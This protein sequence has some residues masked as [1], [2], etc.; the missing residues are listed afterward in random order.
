MEAE[1]NTAAGVLRVVVQS[2][3]PAAVSRK[4][5]LFQMRG[6]GICVIRYSAEER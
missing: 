3:T 5:M 1:A 2:N 6:R 4:P